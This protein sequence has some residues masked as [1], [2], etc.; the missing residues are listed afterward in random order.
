MLKQLLYNVFLEII[1]NSKKFDPNI[2]NQVW[3]ILYHL[4]TYAPS[5]KGF[6]FCSSF[7]G[8]RFHFSTVL[9]ALKHIHKHSKNQ[10]EK[11]MVKILLDKIQY[12]WDAVKDRDMVYRTKYHEESLTEL[13]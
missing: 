8:H 5:I 12:S 13:F 4:V 9:Q 7:T 3:L 1:I 11:D 10:A 2:V 6:L